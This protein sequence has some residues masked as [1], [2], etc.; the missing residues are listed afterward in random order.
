[1]LKMSLT[2][3]LQDSLYQILYIKINSFVLQQ[4]LHNTK[5]RT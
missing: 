1:M 5:V 3:H 2:I 4:S